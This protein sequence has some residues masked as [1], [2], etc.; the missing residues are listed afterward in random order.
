M[1]QVY[2]ARDTRL[3]RSVAIK[4]LPPELAADPDRR[5]RFEREAHAIAAL[6]HPHICTVFDIGRENRT[7]YLVM[8]LLEGETLAERLGQG[9]TRPLPMNDVLR[10]AIEI[11]DALDKAHRAGIVHRDLKPAN[12][13]LTRSGAKLLDFGLAKLKGP[14]VPISMTAIEQATTTGGPKTASGTILGTLHYMAPEQVEG[15][16]ADARADIWA[17]G[18]IL[19]EMA[20]GTRPFEGESPASIIG[21]IL[22]DTPVPAAAR[23][24]VVPEALDRLIR[25]CLQKDPDDRWQSARDVEFGLESVRDSSISSKVPVSK[26]RWPVATSAALAALVCGVSVWFLMWSLEARRLDGL[27][28]QHAARITHES[29]FSEWPTW[30]PDGRQFAFSSNRGGDFEIYVRRV[31]G[32]QDVNVTNSSMDDVQPMISP[33]GTSIA[34]VSTRSSHTGLIKVGSLLG[35]NTRTNGGDIWIT[36]TFGGQAR[37]LAENGNFPVWEPNGRSVIYVTGPESHREIARVSVDGGQPTAVLPTSASRWEI[38]RLAYAPGGH[39]ITF[40]TIDRTVFAMPATGGTPTELLSGTSH[41]WDSSGRR[42]YYVSEEADASTRIE[43]ADIQ[44]SSAG[45]RVARVIVAGVSAGNLKDL[46]IAPD[47]R[48]LLA[49]NNEESLNLTRVPLSPDGASIAGTEE[50]LS[51][52][53]VRDRY[54]FVSPDGT[55]IIVGSNRTGDEE[56]WMLELASRRWQRIGMPTMIGGSTAQACWTRDSRH[57]VAMRYSN[58]GMSAFWRVALD[59]SSTEQILPPRPALGANS[60]CDVSPD[61]SSI[62]YLR[63]VDG[64]SQVFVFDLATR[65]ERQLTTS[66]SQK[67]AAIWSPDGRWVAFSAN[68]DGTVQVWRISVAGGSEAKE[69]QLTTGVERVV[70]FFYSPD[71]R[72][73]YVQP[74]HRNIQRMPADG[75]VPKAVTHFTE[76]GLFL[77]EPSISPDGRWLVYNRGKGGSSL[78]LLTLGTS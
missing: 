72:W 27:V 63:T 46:A 9:K 73:L 75:G 13:M 78:W 7:D 38:V 76:H 41:V 15:R 64:F 52:G 37:R 61:N 45:L 26:L 48:H 51:D 62:V 36:S 12:I 6:S 3:N 28:V 39:W 44:D 69:E 56:L 23:Q 21:A 34:F 24:P 57:L 74:S 54:P 20:T 32:G 31:E 25:R 30:S 58:N 2:K 40:E 47:G 14:V 17:L 50:E 8:E 71:G 4:V 11:A 1:G 49:V 19:Y 77:E 43:A 35:F 29:G 59:G 65:R 5:G 70:H 10:Y 68:T 60:G 42:L 53:L 16:D 55:R 22:K 18:V 33:D 66:S 67:Y